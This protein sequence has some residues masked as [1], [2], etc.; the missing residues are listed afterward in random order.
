MAQRRHWICKILIVSMIVMGMGTWKKMGIF[1]FAESKPNTSVEVGLKKTDTDAPIAPTFPRTDSDAL[2]EESSLEWETSLDESA[3]QEESTRDTEWVQ[4]TESSEKSETSSTQLWR[5]TVATEKGEESAEIWMEETQKSETPTP[6]ESGKQEEIPDSGEDWEETEEI[7]EIEETEEIEKE[8]SVDTSDQSDESSESL[9]ISESLDISS[10]FP[11]QL[12]QKK[13]AVLTE[14][15]LI[16]TK[17]QR[18]ELDVTAQLKEAVEVIDEHIILSES[19]IEAVPENDG[20]YTLIVKTEDENGYEQTMRQTFSV[21]RFGSVYTFSDYFL[22]LR[23]SYTKKVV[24]DLV[25][26]E[27]NPDRLL[28]HSL[29]VEISRDNVPLKNVDCQIRST[30]EHSLSGKRGWYQYE[31]VIAASNFRQDGVYRIALSSEDEAGNQSETANFEAGN[32]VFRVDTTPPEIVYIRRL[33]EN[34]MVQFQV[35]DAIGLKR[36]RAY[37]NHQMIQVYEAEDDITKIEGE[38]TFAGG[39]NQTIQLIAEDLAGNITDTNQFSEEEGVLMGLLPGKEAQAGKDDGNSGRIAVPVLAVLFGIKCF[40]RL[41][42]IRK[43][44]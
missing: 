33:E 32:I 4:V 28:A 43:C 6:S 17:T 24:Q 3:R 9:K 35:F 40:F 10:K 12:P 7:E 42:K 44:D 1:S 20:V 23:N 21:N 5:E 13:A 11:P 37:V 19:Q 25:I 34:E 14:I 41:K 2:T 8:E 26:T 29:K 22:S 16:Q 18:K 39:K 36:V 30:G 31:Y 38:F 27:W 15:T